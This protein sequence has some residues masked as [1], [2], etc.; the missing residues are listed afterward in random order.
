MVIM[1]SGDVIAQAIEAGPSTSCACTSPLL[2]GGGTPL[3][4][5]GSTWDVPPTRGPPVARRRRTYEQLDIDEP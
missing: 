1:G 3:F 5:A 4:R 2:L